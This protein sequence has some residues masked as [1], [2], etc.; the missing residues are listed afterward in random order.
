[1]INISNLKF[2]QEKLN[3]SQTVVYNKTQDLF[4]S[5]DW[6]EK[7][8]RLFVPGYASRETMLLAEL[9]K[10]KLESSLI[11]PE[12]KDEYKKIFRTLIKR[13]PK[14]TKLSNLEKVLCQAHQD[15]PFSHPKNTAALAKWERNGHDATI[16]RNHPEF[17]KFMFDSNLLS[18]MKI[19]EDEIR[20]I[21]GE[22]HILVEG[23]W[24]SGTTLQERFYFETSP[25]YKEVF[26][27]DKA[28]TEVY[29]YL[30]N[31]QGLQK[32]HPYLTTALTPIQI[33]S[34]EKYQVVLEKAKLFNR[35]GMSDAHN[36]V[37]QIVSSYTQG[38]NTNAANFVA[39]SRHTYLRM[40]AGR[41]NPEFGTKKGGV[42][43]VGFGWTKKSS[44]PFVAGSGQFRSPDSWEYMPSKERIVTNVPV[45]AE[46]AKNLFLF[47]KK[48]HNESMLLGKEI[49]FHLAQQNCSVYVRNA[50]QAAGIT[51]PTEIILPNLISKISPDWMKSIERGMKK[52]REAIVSFRKKTIGLL[53][54][55]ISG[56][57]NKGIETIKHIVKK[58]FDTLVSLSFIPLR[59]M[60][61]DAF[62]KEGRAFNLDIETS[63]EKIVPP[64]HNPRNYFDLSRFKFNMPGVLQEWQRKQ[65]S[66]E[67]FKNPIRLA[68]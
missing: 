50:L 1:M 55:G 40:I 49:A 58:A 18:Q 6:K 31:G 35:E 2:A 65:A 10:Q 9:I 8:K 53:S 66:T 27:L 41:D 22:P 37:I 39:N 54:L 13:N 14:H 52:S 42:Y 47:T 46:E 25:R 45:T 11:T 19:S 36:F 43:E 20:L 26:I 62:G 16:F 33:L 15:L 34:E 17:A 48:F 51:V 44:I 59:F 64:L 7:A 4:E 67:I 30:G 29:T 68:I 38:S 12:F 21:E 61:G 60:L 23:K 57:L 56:A 63:E 28:T 32:H 5:A 24:T 3:L